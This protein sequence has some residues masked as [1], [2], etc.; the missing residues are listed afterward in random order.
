MR[1][2]IITTLIVTAA[3]VMSVAADAQPKAELNANFSLVRSFNVPPVSI[4]VLQSELFRKEGGN[5]TAADIVDLNSE[6]AQKHGKPQ[7]LPP[8]IAPKTFTIILKFPDGWWTTNMIRSD[9]DSNLACRVKVKMTDPRP[10]KELFAKTVDWCH[11]VLT[12]GTLD[13]SLLADP[14]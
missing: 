6:F 12:A 10:D 13:P 7:F 11:G 5:V 3:A 4:D 1:K 2:R 8:Q 14:H 9:G